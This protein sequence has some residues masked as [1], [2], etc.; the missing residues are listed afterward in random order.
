MR[1]QPSRQFRRMSELNKESIMAV[2]TFN[3]LIMDANN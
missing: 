2:P 3:I 1:G